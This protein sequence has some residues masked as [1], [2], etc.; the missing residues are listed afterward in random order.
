MKKKSPNNTNH[1]KSAQNKSSLTWLYWLTVAVGGV[2]LVFVIT[3]I[4][5]MVNGISPTN[6]PSLFVGNIEVDLRNGCGAPGVARR[7]EEFLRTKG[8]DVR[9]VQ[10]ADHF[11]YQRSI[12]VD[13]RGEMGH[14]LG[15]AK[16]LGISRAQITRRPQEDGL[17]EMT[18]IIGYDF[19]DLE[20]FKS[21]PQVENPE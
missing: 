16:L 8:Y 5:R 12:I 4:D 7:F 2:A 13:Y 18:L 11:N 15:L 10:N 20:P 14:A 17:W 21:M 1:T 9:N 6:Q 19:V 3:L